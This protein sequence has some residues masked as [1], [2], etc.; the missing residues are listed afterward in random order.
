[1]TVLG[2]VQRSYLAG[3]HGH[4][5]VFNS[6]L[7]RSTLNYQFTRTLSLRTILDYNGI[8]PNSSLAGMVVT[9][10]RKSKKRTGRLSIGPIPAV[11]NR[12]AAY[13]AA[14]QALDSSNSPKR[15]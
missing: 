3:I 14:P 15:F 12:R 8:L 4:A 9:C 2:T 13:Q 11:G 5:A 7:L 6:H 10:W 1:M